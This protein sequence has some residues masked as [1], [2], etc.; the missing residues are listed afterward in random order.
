M[1]H[2]IQQPKARIVSV[3]LIMVNIG[4]ARAQNTSTDVFPII[5]VQHH[6]MDNDNGGPVLPMCPNTSK[7]TASDP[8]SDKGQDCSPKLCTA[9][10]RSD[11]T[12]PI[13]QPIKQTWLTS[14]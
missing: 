3:F 8:K 12:D 14:S 9:G 4:V 2:L 7:F 1:L 6:A 5:D 11:H 13:R 10:L